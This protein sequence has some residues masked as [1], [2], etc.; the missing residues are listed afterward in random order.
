MCVVISTLNHYISQ[1]AFL[2]SLRQL[3]QTLTVTYE[4]SARFPLRVTSSETVPWSSHTEYWD[5]VSSTLDHCSSSL[6]NTQ[7][8]TRRKEHAGRNT[9]LFK[10][11]TRQSGLFFN[12]G[13]TGTVGNVEALISLVCFWRTRIPDRFREFCG[14]LGIFPPDL[15]QV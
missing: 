13:D 5:W 14:N 15:W 4:D 2:H 11:G 10:M 12:I 7:E 3:A 6:G 1:H 9:G 8:G